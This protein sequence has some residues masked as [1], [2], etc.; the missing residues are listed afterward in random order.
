[1]WLVKTW[2]RKPSDPLDEWQ[3]VTVAPHVELAGLYAR[4]IE[5][6][7]ELDMIDRDIRR[8]QPEVPE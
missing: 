7:R 6:L 3:A 8:L 4:R 1:M 5:V 2:R